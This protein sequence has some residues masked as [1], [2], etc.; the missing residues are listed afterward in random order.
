MYKP[1]KPNTGKYLYFLLLL[2]FVSCQR[3]VVPV[4]SKMAGNYKNETDFR[5]YN[6][7]FSEAIKQKNLGNYAQ[8]QKYYQQC[9]IINPESDAV[10]FELSKL[11]SYSGDYNKSLDYAR[12]AEK[13]DKGNIWYK[14]QLA[15]LYSGLGKADSSIMVYEEIVAM[16]PQN[17]DYKYQLAKLYMDGERN[18]KALLLFDEIEND[19]GLQES[20]SV[21]KAEIYRR[22]NKKQQAIKELEKLNEISDDNLS[23]KLMYVEMLAESGETERAREE[24]NNLIERYSE[25]EELKISRMKFYI[26]TKEYNKLMSLTDSLLLNDD[27]RIETKF[28]IVVYLFSDPLLLAEIKDSL[29]YS[30]NRYREKYNEEIKITALIGDYYV[31]CGNYE[32]ASLEFK[33]YLE[34]DK[35]NY[36]VWEQLL[37]LQNILGENEDMYKYSSAAI[38]LFPKSAILYLFKGTACSAMELDEE[39]IE[40][41]KS[42]IERVNNNND[43]LLQFYSVIGE[44]YKNVGM[45]DLSDRSFEKGLMIDPNN[46]ILLNNYSYYLSLRGE[47]L[48]KAEEMS[49]KTIIAEP[50]NSTYLDTYGWILYKMKKYRKAETYLKKAID[51]DNDISAEVFE[52]Y[53]DVNYKLRK[54]D[55]AIKFWEKAEKAG[56]EAGSLKSKI[57]KAKKLK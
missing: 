2:L 44:C 45:N 52:H 31:K 25:N 20:V 47:N 18:E 38:E 23:Y 21:S 1:Y 30:L 27:T 6:Y 35:R 42:G 34:K 48:K 3:S 16:C 28:D 22:N 49:S 50:N 12:M 24:Y 46:Q 51:N 54:Y 57:Q 10:M 7:L 17:L 8:A 43:L 33:S 39:A 15:G 32:N 55:T 40:I 13:T 11:N 26:I 36:L 9:L 4:S 5:N 37:F 53:G 29:Y 14:L 19:V 56:G 41:L